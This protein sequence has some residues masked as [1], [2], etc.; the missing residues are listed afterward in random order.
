MSGQ[1][2]D[3]YELDEQAVRWPRIR[4]GRV[5]HILVVDDEEDFLELTE[6]FLVGDGFRVSKARSPG[7]ALWAAAQSPPDLAILDL[8]LPHGNGIQILRA[9]R[10]EPETA[11]IP[12]FACTAVDIEDVESVLRAG[13]DGHFPKPV[14]WPALRAVIRK[15]FKRAM[16]PEASG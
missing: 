9:L 10:S 13:F 5:P 14:N 2:G 12:I 7:E 1:P 6:M 3:V 8:L 15:L 11:D 4:R 16:E